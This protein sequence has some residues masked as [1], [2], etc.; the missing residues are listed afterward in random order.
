MVAPCASFAGS[1]SQAEG[2]LRRGS[3]LRHADLTHLT[4]LTLKATLAH[5]SARAH[6]H[7]QGATHTRRDTHM[8]GNLHTSCCHARTPVRVAEETVASQMNPRSRRH[9]R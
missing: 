5:T 8:G 4:H 1:S 7:T 2:A 3:V 6:A 9:T